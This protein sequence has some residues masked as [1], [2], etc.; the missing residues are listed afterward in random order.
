[1]KAFIGNKFIAGITQ[2]IDAEH[3]GPKDYINWQKVTMGMTREEYA[4]FFLSEGRTEDSVKN[5]I[6]LNQFVLNEETKDV[7]RS[8]GFVPGII[9]RE[10]EG[11]AADTIIYIDAL[12]YSKS[13]GDDLIVCYTDGSDE[14]IRIPKKIITLQEGEG[15]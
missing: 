8:D 15:I 4:A 11:L 6:T 1:M 10:Y 2:F 9:T 14:M 7:G 12:D 3:F 13:A 5:I